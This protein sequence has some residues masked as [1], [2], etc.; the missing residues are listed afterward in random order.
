MREGRACWSPRFSHTALIQ[1]ESASPT[2]VAGAGTLVQVASLAGRGT[3]GAAQPGLVVKA[4]SGIAPRFVNVAV[5]PL[6]ES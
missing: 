4:R 6:G 1:V 3:M 2:S 5:A